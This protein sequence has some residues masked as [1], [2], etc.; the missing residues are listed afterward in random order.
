M[1]QAEKKEM[2]QDAVAVFIAGVI[3][4]LWLWAQGGPVG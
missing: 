3:L 4:I 1:T 2:W